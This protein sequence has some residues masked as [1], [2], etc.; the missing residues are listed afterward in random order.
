MAF[1]VNIKYENPVV[2]YFGNLALTTVGDVWAYYRIRPF[3]INVANDSDK[4]DYKSI[5]INI[6]ER[7]QSF[8]ELDLQLVPSDMDLKGRI[9]GTRDDWA[10]DIP[11][12]P[13]YY[14]GQEET[15]IL[16]SEFDPA[17]IDEFYIGVKLKAHAV[18]TGVRDRI[19]FASNLLLKSAAEM[20]KFSVKFDDKF[21]DRYQIMN[22]EVYSILR[23]MNVSKV[24]EETLIKL[25]GTPYHHAD[26]RLFSEMRNTVFDL[27]KQGIVKRDNGTETDYVSH[28]VINLPTN[29][30]NFDIMPK[31]QSFNFPIE[32]HFKIRFPPR[33]GLLGIKESADWAKE[34]YKGE[35]EDAEATRDTASAKSEMN[36][37]MATDLVE[38][39]DT[40]NAF[41]AWTM[42]LVI[43]DSDVNK[44]KYKISKVSTALQG[45]NKDL[46]VY[47]PSFHQEMLLYQIL[48]GAPLGGFKYWQ[49]YTSAITFAELLFGTTTQLGT[50]TGFYLGRVLTN[51]YYDSVE[52]AAASSRVLVLFNLIIANKG[53]K[54]TQTDSPHI[55]ISGVTGSGKSFLFKTLLLHAGMFD[56]DILAFDPKQEMRR[57]FSRALETVDNQYFKTLI[58]AF[59]FITLDYTDL[60]N[61]GVID[62]LNT[63]SANSTADEIADVSTLI[64]EML[65]QIRSVS[66]SISLETALTDSIRELCKQRLRGEKVGTL[67]I[68]DLLRARGGEAEELGNYYQSIIPDSMLRLAFG[69]GQG[70]HLS[71][72]H[73]RTILEVSGLDLPKVTDHADTYTDSNK[74]SISIMLALGRFM[75][76]FGRRNTD[77]FSAE[78]MD[79]AWVFETSS[80]GK[81]VLDSIKR[82]GRS[83]N[84]ELITSSQLV[85]DGHGK[86][87]TGQYGQ[88]FA[89]DDRDDRPNILKQFGQPVNKENIDMLANLRKGQCL[90]RDLY[91]R[92]G[93]MVVHS[94]FDEWTEAF[95]TVNANSSSDL[96]SKYS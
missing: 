39:L 32:T 13:D 53:I 58:S 6:M 67:G 5:L 4:D 9:S 33:D 82:L 83:E 85:S 69:D 12:V 52:T 41:M 14:M 65:V 68:V 24:S 27:S 2:Q 86:E 91:G 89:F 74:Y 92:V 75:E 7:L 21:F 96:E 36:F 81:K 37:S 94:L 25:L 43:R 18:G 60:K 22:D 79:E 35:Y 50:N 10:K 20:F 76:R 63:L 40:D 17:V 71:L 72:E 80:A 49:N 64:R 15:N 30:E 51:D 23:A 77:R 34:K 3:Q 26:K 56:M 48:V 88:I 44:L 95:K 8:G 57:W 87:S 93:K 59:H 90:Y 16:Q 19:K 45:M 84:N 78:F 47:Q 55:N 38:L 61:N 42:I 28:L 73:Q 29:L 70:D 46:S 11:E 62:P 66:H 31:I 1:G 54:G